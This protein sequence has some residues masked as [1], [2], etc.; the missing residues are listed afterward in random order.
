MQK[1]QKKCALMQSE[2]A[3]P[4][5]EMEERIARYEARVE[6]LERETEA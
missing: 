6:Q 3:A 4:Q 5:R 1:L 2:L